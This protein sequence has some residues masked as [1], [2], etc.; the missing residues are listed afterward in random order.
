M[1]PLVRRALGVAV[2][3]LSAAAPAV[4]APSLQVRGELVDLSA[5][6][7]LV[8]V[9]VHQDAGTCPDRVVV[10]NAV[11]GGVTRLGRDGGATCPPGDRARGGITAVALGGRRAQWTTA[12]GGN[13]E[14]T[15]TLITA[16]LD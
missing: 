4:A 15:D 14:S 7:S 11:R 10:W 16:S 2:L 5:D 6:G 1:P 12:F 9:A 8:A 13:T 3:L